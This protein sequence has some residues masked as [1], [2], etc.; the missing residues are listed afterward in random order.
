[1]IKKIYIIILLLISIVAYTQEKK[2]ISE[3]TKEDVLELTYDELL[4]MPFEDVLKLAEIVGVSMEELYE[5]LLNKDVSSASKKAESSFE[6]PLSTSVVS[7]DEIVSSGAR[8]IEEALRLVPG[9]IVREKTNGNFDAH[10]RGNDNLP[11]NHMFLYSENSITLVMIDGRPV[12][13]YVHGGTF[14]ETLPI[15]IDDV[16]RIEVVRG[17]SSA[18]YGPNAVSGVVNIITRKQENKKLNVTANVQGGSQSTFISSMGVGAGI[19]DKLSFKLTGNFET[20]D[21]NTDELYVH[22]ANNGEGGFITKE[23]L[24]DLTDANGIPVFDP[25]DDVNKMYPDPK[26]ARERYG[27][28]GYL[29]YDLEDDVKFNLK[30]GFQ[31]S[32]VLS[33]TMADN[34][35]AM[36]GRESNTGYVDFIAKVK[37]LSAQ[38]NF[39]DGWQDVVK[40]DTGFKIDIMNVNANFEYDI[41]VGNLNIRPGFSYQLGRYNDMN[42]LRYE[43]QGFLN[44][45]Q[46]F[47]TTALSLRLDYLAFERLRL[48][49]AVRGEKYNTHDDA[50]FSYQ[51]IA[52]YNL[53]DIHNFRIVHSRA[54][55]GPFLVDNYANFLWDRT[56]RTA[57]DYI[58][59]RG[60]K[61]LDLLTMNMFEIGYRIK[62][63]KNVQ[64]DFELFYNIAN[65]FGAL[66]PDSATVVYNGTPG[67]TYT[68]MTYSNIDMKSTQYGIT[69]SVDWVVNKDFMVKVFGTYQKSEL[70]SIMPFSPDDA[71]L[72]LLL[73][74]S[75]SPT[76][77]S[78]YF[79][80]EREDVENKATPSF[81]GG[82]VLNYTYKEKLSFNLNGYYYSEQEFNNKYG[83]EIIESRLILNLK[84]T[85]KAHKNATVFVN[86][87]NILGE[88]K[89][90]GY[91]DTI[92][93]LFM[94]GLTLNY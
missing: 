45:E 31:S 42:Y 73:D 50:Y 93:T 16:D 86:A 92:G 1:M 44:G 52:S 29:F 64:A 79:P 28:N 75:S 57:P 77:T 38:I 66:Y 3:M 91:M 24:A 5:M 33:S 84:A 83:T 62:P 69:G 6:A 25:N 32:E 39:L 7:Y 36:A 46:E 74:A 21:R 43:G 17:P 94:G 72:F 20:L 81:Y 2:D 80:T 19:T 90:F 60:Q 14:W 47:S 87:R 55:R 15:G 70:E 26:K 54:N 30:G 13:N 37:G 41:N 89:Q 4:E 85:Y 67:V 40:Q 78:T 11:P 22:K 65:D 8:S 23:E 27:I 88:Q 56:G 48:I 71:T 35:S 61:N 53:N 76:G 49:G 51:L 68:Q 63:V 10:I 59:F 18:L 9:M 12:Y 34:P 58:Y 82:L